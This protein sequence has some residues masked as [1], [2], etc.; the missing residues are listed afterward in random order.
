[1]SEEKGKKERHRRRQ[2]AKQEEERKLA[3]CH[4][5]EH[6]APEKHHTA[7]GPPDWNTRGD[8]VAS[9]QAQGTRT[10]T[11]GEERK[12]R[13]R[14]HQYWSI[15]GAE[16]KGW[17]TH[18][19]K[20]MEWSVRGCTGRKRQRRQ[21]I[22]LASRGGHQQEK[23]TE[24][25]TQK[26]TAGETRRGSHTATKPTGLEHPGGRRGKQTSTR[27]PDRKIW[28]RTAL[29][30]SVNGWG[31]M[32]RRQQEKRGASQGEHEQEQVMDG[33]GEEEQYGRREGE[34]RAAQ[35]ETTDKA[36]RKDKVG[37]AW[38]ADKRTE[39]VREHPANKV[40]AGNRATRT[41]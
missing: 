26:E 12:G 34:E 28:G 27:S 15:R 17:A 1:M 21:E 14:G 30:R 9:G 8:A 4:G 24:R 37:T 25:R 11:S 3:G 41:G 23:G 7:T 5:Q 19:G 33:R 35:N 31:K 2:P 39:S 6:P 29:E 40:P 32:R 13:H 38:Q 10:G 36:R 18:P 22:K 16:T 20:I